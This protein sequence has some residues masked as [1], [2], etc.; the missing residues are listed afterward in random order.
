MT[1]LRCLYMQQNLVEKIENLQHCQMLAIINLESNQVKK[2]ENLDCLPA[3]ETLHLGKNHLSS[4]ESLE[5]LKKLLNLTGM[6]FSATFFNI[7]FNFLFPH[8]SSNFL[9]KMFSF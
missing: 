9:L 1:I 3:L 5:H 7:D 4:Y 6:N 8:F 2:I